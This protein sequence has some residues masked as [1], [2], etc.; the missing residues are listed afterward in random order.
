MVVRQSLSMMIILF[1]LRSLDDCMSSN[2]RK[3]S[4]ADTL[5]R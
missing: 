2:L 5:C 1:V 3:S 4:I